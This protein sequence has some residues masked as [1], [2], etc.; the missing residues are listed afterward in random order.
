M[1]KAHYRGDT[2]YLHMT[3][4]MGYGE[5]STESIFFTNRAAP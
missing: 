4:L 2:S 3:K 1:Q 5:G